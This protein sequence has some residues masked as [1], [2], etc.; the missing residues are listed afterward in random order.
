MSDFLDGSLAAEIETAARKH[1]EECFSCATRLKNFQKI[2]SALESQ[3]RF[4]LPKALR[5]QPLSAVLP[6]ITASKLSLSQWE[7]LP[8]YIRTILETIGVIGLVLLGIS[9]APNIRSLFERSAER[10]LVDFKD[11]F[12][13]SQTSA[14]LAE[15]ALPVLEQVADTRE[16]PKEDD[17]LANSEGESSE[18]G[19]LQVGNSQLWRFT[20]KTVS[21]DELRSQVIKALTDLKIPKNTL[22][23]GGVQVPGGIEFK[24]ILPQHL[25]LDVKHALEGLVISPSKNSDGESKGAAVSDNFTWYRVNSKRKV[26]EG[27]SQVVIWLS[28]PN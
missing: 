24:M 3:Q 13:L 1:F 12:P 26:P 20:L 22:G 19:G 21:P 2:I 5:E 4:I 18:G 6:R 15:A 25:V 14:D 16:Q 17:D 9:S 10:T 8:W 11:T 23:L 28:Q 7:R 27:K